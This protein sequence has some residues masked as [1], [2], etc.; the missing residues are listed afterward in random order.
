M[1]KGKIWGEVKGQSILGGEDFVERFL[2]HVR[3]YQKI[4]EI[5]RGQRFLGW[6]K[7]GKLWEGGGR[8]FEEKGVDIRSG[9]GVGV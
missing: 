3:G 2:D 4:W 1:G 8:S 6:P 7:L 5:L 9:R